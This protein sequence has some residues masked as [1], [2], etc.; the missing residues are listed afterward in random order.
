[1]DAESSQG[2]RGAADIRLDMESASAQ[3]ATLRF[4]PE[5]PASSSLE[6]LPLGGQALAALEDIAIRQTLALTRGNKVQAARLLG[7]ATSTL[8]EKLKRHG[9]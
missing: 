9:L 3:R 4:A 1:M 8:Y 7:I 6:R 5:A 2:A